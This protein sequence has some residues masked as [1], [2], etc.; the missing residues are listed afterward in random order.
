[1]K[2]FYKIFIVSTLLAFNSGINAVLSE[3]QK[4][5]NILDVVAIAKGIKISGDVNPAAIT[6]PYPTGSIFATPL[7]LTAGQQLTEFNY[8]PQF[9]DGTQSDLQLGA[10][11]LLKVGT[12][13]LTTVNAAIA[14]G[15]SV[16]FTANVMVNGSVYEALIA[17]YD[18]SNTTTPIATHLFS[19]VYSW[20][21]NPSV[22][23]HTNTNI[24]IAATNN[25]WVSSWVACSVDGGALHSEN[26]GSDYGYQINPPAAAPS[27]TPA[28]YPSTTYPIYSP[29][30]SL[31]VGVTITAFSF[32][33][34]FSD[35][36]NNKTFSEMWVSST[37]LALITAGTSVVFTANLGKN[38]TGGYDG[39]VTAY[40]SVTNAV[41]FSQPFPS[42]KLYTSQ[43]FEVSSTNISS[44]ASW[45]DSYIAYS[46][47][48]GAGGPVVNG[49]PTNGSTLYTD[50]GSNY[51]VSFTALSAMTAT[52][53]VKTYATFKSFIEAAVSPA[54]V[55]EVYDNTNPSA[56]AVYINLAGNGL[57]IGQAAWANTP[58]VPLPN[59]PGTTTPM[60]W[61]NGAPVIFVLLPVDS[62][63][64]IIKD[65]S[66]IPASGPTSL[67]LCAYDVSGNLIGESI[68]ATSSMV[69]PTQTTQGSWNT[70]NRMTG[71]VLGAEALCN[72]YPLV[73]K[74]NF[75]NPPA[76]FGVSTS[77]VC[78]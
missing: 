52:Q 11:S 73:L 25:G 28:L 71:S 41:I 16:V 49:V 60:T 67:M 10:Q 54:T 68:V 2:L 61:A 69:I 77:A 66:L 14:A 59:A 31:P 40:N 18:T 37:N 46:L 43:T 1:M 15:K 48:N 9:K 26:L 34:N 39:V 38:A 20:T 30:V 4:V 12:A 42:I 65:L 36:S 19:T 57:A 24:P 7:S 8:Y 45:N 75:P 13:F 3:S 35:K 58:F 21:Y 22:S 62:T 44:T 32:S 74:V 53:A 55:N 72:S 23:K 64:T 78:S 17:A 76:G 5:L 56:A 27:V 50:I 51:G 29:A 6:A 70:P 47:S 63:D 33:P